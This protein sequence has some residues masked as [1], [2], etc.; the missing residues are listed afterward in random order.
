MR[1]ERTNLT[2]SML[3][4]AGLHLAVFLSA[5]IVWPWFG[6][7]VQ[8]ANV[9]AV[10]LVPSAAAPPPPALQAH[11]EQTAAAPEPTP[12]PAKPVP[13][14][15]PQPEAEP[16]PSP[17][18][19]TP[20]QPTPAPSP[21]P[22]PAPKPKSESLDLNALANTL[23]KS[24]KSQNRTRSKDSLD[25]SALTSS[26][27]KGGKPEAAAKG[28][29]RFETSISP[30]N[31][32]GAAQATTDAAA[33][34]GARLN[35]IWN[36]SCGVEGFRDLVIRVKFN[37]TIE[38]QLA[39]PPQVLDPAPQGNSVWQAAADRAVRAVNQAAPF[40][41]LPRQTYGQWKSFT[42]IFNGREACQNP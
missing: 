36:K 15:P 35:R 37:L 26:L 40:A 19:P 1:R 32:P 29:A 4:A 31:D 9:T 8:I 13:P 39:G 25:L 33:A 12:K 42:A 16:K 2:P 21:S 34:V 22:K 6:K 38:G 11:E 7:P 10:T 41:E 27:D 20:P 5:L 14:P 24:A 3:A 23:D 18:K 17:P 28:P 30:R